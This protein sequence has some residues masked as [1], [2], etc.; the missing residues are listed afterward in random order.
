MPAEMTFPR[1]ISY[2]YRLHTSLRL[3][4]ISSETERDYTDKFELGKG[5]GELS[6]YDM[7]T[8]GKQTVTVAYKGFTT[9]FDIEVV[10]VKGI[11]VEPAENAVYV[12][13]DQSILFRNIPYMHR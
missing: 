4:E 10:G 8:P 11:R 5:L 9:T 12:K 1:I 7:N 2:I 3:A 13:G 6:G